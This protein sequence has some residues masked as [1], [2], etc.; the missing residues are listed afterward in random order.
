[1]F[2]Q[3]A[4]ITLLPQPGAVAQTALQV[5]IH[6]R[7]DEAQNVLSL[8]LRS[9]DGSP[10]PPFNAGAHVEVEL[11]N[12]LSRSYSLVN[13]PLETH[14][15]VI[16]VNR[17]RSSRGGSQFIH[18]QLQ[19]GDFLSISAPRNHFPLA[20][21]AQCT[22]MFA[23]GIGVTPLYSMAQ[24]LDVL[25]RPWEMHYFARSRANAAFAE[26]LVQ[27]ASRGHCSMHFHFDD[28]AGSRTE[29]A[30]RIA[31]APAFAHLYCCGPA[32]M[33]DAFVDACRPRPATHVHLERFA[34]DEAPAVE[35][36]FDVVLARSEKTIR[37]APGQTILDA[38][39]ARGVDAPH[40]CQE[41]VCGSCETR[42]LEGEPDHRDSVLGPDERASKQTMMICCSG[43]KSAT[44]VL[45]L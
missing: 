12:G 43:C 21:D 19:A 17:D 14:R 34:A 2:T 8:D 13:T 37:I 45:D 41:G 15:Y 11:P 20:E 7:R 23:G 10:L 16:A 29:L 24:R 18:E 9:V 6:A 39:L 4:S 26:A 5:R 22:V 36:G 33:L 3:S 28:A 40:S 38:V 27:L 25:Q 35:G 32:P 42:V 44:L 31:S 30:R 1:M